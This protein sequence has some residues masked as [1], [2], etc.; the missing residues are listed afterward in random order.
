MKNSLKLF[1]LSIVLS[2]VNI[3]GF[4]NT[5]VKNYIDSENIIINEEQIYLL[6]EEG[7]LQPLSA[8]Y[9]DKKGLY[10]LAQDELNQPMEEE[11]FSAQDI[12]GVLES[13][14]QQEIAYAQDAYRELTAGYEC[15]CGHI[16]P[17]YRKTCKSCNKT[18]IH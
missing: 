12:R 2:I 5:P 14:I 9:S 10:I 4:A 1:G 8:I 11:A 15:A 16:N 3:S 7:N 6:S 17:R 18:I 13:N